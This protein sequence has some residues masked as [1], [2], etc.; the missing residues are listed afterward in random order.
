MRKPTCLCGECKKC[1][2]REQQRVYYSN[3]ENLK[4][5]RELKKINRAKNIEVYRAREREYGRTPAA[6]ARENERRRLKKAQLRE[7]KLAAGLILPLKK[8]DAELARIKSA[9]YTAVKFAKKSGRLKQGPC[10][11]CGTTTRV[12]AHHEDYSKPLEVTWL[13]RRHHIDL[14]TE[15]RRAEIAA[16]YAAVAA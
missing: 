13:C 4:R 11:V 15:R 16:L 9:A 6:R 14:H 5:K 1:R 7:E 8:D 2:L 10:A 3:P 12:D